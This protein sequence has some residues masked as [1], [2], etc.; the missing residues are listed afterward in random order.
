MIYRALRR[1]GALDLKHS[2]GK[3]DIQL[4]K[5]AVQ[6]HADE[7]LTAERYIWQ[8]P[9]T[10]YNEWQAS[11]YLENIFEQAGYVLHKA[12]NIPGFYTDVETGKAGPKVLVLCE[13]DGLY[14]PNHF[15]AVNGNA[16]ACGHHAQCA[17]MVGIALA[18][19]E[20]NV[21]NGLS[22]SIRLCAVP[23]EE[24]IQSDFRESLR[25]KEII[26]YYGG[27][28]E[29]LYRGYFDGV[30]MAILFHTGPGMKHLF[31]VHAGCNGNIQ[32]HFAF[33]GVASHAGGSPQNGINALYAAPLSL[34]AINALRETF[35]DYDHVRVHPI[36]TEGGDSVSVIPSQTKLETL[37]RGKSLAVIGKIN[38]KVNRAIASG[39]LAMGATVTVADRTGAAPLNNSREL[40]AVAVEALNELVGADMVH[41]TE[42]WGG[43]ST[44]MGDLSCVMPVIHPYVA[45]ATGKSHGDD[46]R[47]DEPE[48]ACI[49]SAEAQVAV[50]TK[51]LQD[52]AKLAK[53]VA[54][55]YTAP[56]AGKEAFFAEWDKFISDKELVQYGKDEIKIQI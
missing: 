36:V 13:L 43:A 27:K 54:E 55:S 46:Y 5:N 42:N 6:R 28:D 31:A 8:H 19:K 17:A 2:G 35:A 44:D 52:D 39:A 3:M 25:R 37:I 34:N 23:A 1:I 50:L 16:H 10:G 41:V 29:F 7:I 20:P 9:E 40:R 4:I 33:H 24:E 45:G 56:Y 22:G 18:L 32:K 49:L 48:K 11:A 30:D 51:L 12:G 26:R 38:E 21:L 47:I 15:A 14:V 53:Y